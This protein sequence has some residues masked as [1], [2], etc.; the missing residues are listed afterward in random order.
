MSPALMLG[1][2]DPEV[3]TNGVHPTSGAT[4][5]QIASHRTEI[6]TEK[7]NSP[8]T[9][10]VISASWGDLDAAVRIDAS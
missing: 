5:T 1:S 2:I 6:T 3:T 10:R 4:M 9:K 7:P 8:K